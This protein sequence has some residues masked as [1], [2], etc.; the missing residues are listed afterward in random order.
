MRSFYLTLTVIKPIRYPSSSENPSL[1]DHIW[2]S[3][4]NFYISV[5]IEN[6]TSDHLPVFVHTPLNVKRT[7]PDLVRV[8]FRL[9]MKSIKFDFM[10]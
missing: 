10:I 8:H 3:K 6:N 1:L 4:I 7:P 5:N 9:I 2:L